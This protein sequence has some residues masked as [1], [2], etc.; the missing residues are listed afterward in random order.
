VR[1]SSAWEAFPRKW[2]HQA[3]LAIRAETPIAVLK[4]IADRC[5]RDVVSLRGVVPGS[6]LLLPEREAWMCSHAHMLV[7]SGGPGKRLGIDMKVAAVFSAPEERLEGVPEKRLAD[8]PTA[9]GATDTKDVDVPAGRV[10]VG[11]F[12]RAGVAGELPSVPGEKPA[13]PRTGACPAVDGES[14]RRST[15][16]LPSGL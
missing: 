6:E 10:L 2:I 11:L 5:R 9:V 15:L 14:P 12:A 8:A 1:I 7:E 3:V 4:P 13:R 16:P